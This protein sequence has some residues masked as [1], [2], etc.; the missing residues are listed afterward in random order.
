MSVEKS[1]ACYSSIIRRID[2]YAEEIL[3]EIDEYIH[4]RQQRESKEED[5]SLNLSYIVSKELEAITGKQECSGKEVFFNVLIVILDSK[6]RVEIYPG[7][8]AHR[9]LKPRDDCSRFYSA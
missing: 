6:M 8:P 7:T 5:P 9:S 3:K 4:E 2:D 1:F